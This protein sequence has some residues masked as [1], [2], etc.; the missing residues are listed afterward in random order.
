MTE[1][2]DEGDGKGRAPKNLKGWSRKAFN[3]AKPGYDHLVKSQA[4]GNQR[5]RKKQ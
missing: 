5:D 3:N 1:F 4:G 2:F